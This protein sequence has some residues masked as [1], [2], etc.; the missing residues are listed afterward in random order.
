MAIALRS[1]RAASTPSH[2]GVSV[3]AGRWR[4]EGES[5]STRR[6]N[7]V[8]VTNFAGRPS[9]G[10]GRFRYCRTLTAWGPRAERVRENS[11]SEHRTGMCG[12]PVRSGKKGLGE[13]EA[14]LWGPKLVGVMDVVA[15]AVKLSQYSES[16]KAGNGLETIISHSSR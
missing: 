12:R 4:R 1:W 9:Q 6:I 10:S 11:L 3:E 14:A 15:A 13:R 8:G 16:M 7:C 2:D 5:R